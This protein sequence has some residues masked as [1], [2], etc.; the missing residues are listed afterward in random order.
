ME[1]NGGYLREKNSKF[2][3]GLR[4]LTFLHDYEAVHALGVVGRV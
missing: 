4:P 2:F 1:L 3:G